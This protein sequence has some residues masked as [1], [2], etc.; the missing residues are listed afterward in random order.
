MAVYP[1]Q[2]L[3]LNFCVRIFFK[4]PADI[5]VQLIYG[6]AARGFY[7]VPDVPPE[8]RYEKYMQVPVSFVNI[9]SSKPPAGGA[10]YIVIASYLLVLVL[11][12]EESDKEH[13]N[14]SFSM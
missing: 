10:N 8:G 6:A 12:P 3:R 2:V 1:V 11:Y 13:T 5:G 7:K 4:R 9:V 14:H